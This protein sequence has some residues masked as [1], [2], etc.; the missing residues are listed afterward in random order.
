MGTVATIEGSGEVSDRAPRV[1]LRSAL[2]AEELRKPLKAL[3]SVLRELQGSGQH[4]H[5]T[6]EQLN[7]AMRGN[8]VRGVFFRKGG[9]KRN[10]E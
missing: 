10:K 8:R 5:L 1:A 3:E 4:G 9:K 7:R 6:V 2:R